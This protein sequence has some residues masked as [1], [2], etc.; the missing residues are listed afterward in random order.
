VLTKIINAN[1]KGEINDKILANCSMALAFLAAYSSDSQ[2][3]LTLSEAF[4]G[5]CLYVC[6]AVIIPIKFGVLINGN[7]S[8]DKKKL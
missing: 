8:C 2:Q 5:S 4:D 1:A 6:D 3:M 7:D